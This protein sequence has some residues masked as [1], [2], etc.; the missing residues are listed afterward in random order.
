M[1]QNLVINPHEGVA[2]IETSDFAVMEI[3]TL[4]RA[5]SD[6]EMLQAVNY[7]KWKLAAGSFLEAEH[8]SDYKDLHRHCLEPL[9]QGPNMTVTASLACPANILAQVS[10]LSSPLNRHLRLLPEDLSGLS[11]P[12][13]CL[14][15]RHAV[16]VA[17][18]GLAHAECS[19]SDEKQLLAPGE[20]PSDM[21]NLHVEAEERTQD[22]H[23]ATCTVKGLVPGA[24]YLYVVFAR[25]TSGHFNYVNYVSVNHG[26]EATMMQDAFPHPR[27]NGVNVHVHFSS[28]A[29]APVKRPYSALQLDSAVKSMAQA[30]PAVEA[31]FTFIHLYQQCDTILLLGGMGVEHCGRPEYRAP[32]SHEWRHKRPLPGALGHGSVLMASCWTE[33]YRL[34]SR[35]ASL[36][37][38]TAVVA[39]ERLQCISGRWYNSL[40]KDSRSVSRSFGFGESACLS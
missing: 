11:T 40:S 37:G 31:G 24:Q 1:D 39:S 7:L 16:G 6:A 5:L 2:Y 13:Q 27:F 36:S 19:G 35:G 34:T 4:D 33:R 14:T 25:D 28:L 18:P 38:A 20:L 23:K 3:I 12:G 21:W 29:I 8:L 32:D 26:R 17:R 30:L 10:S 9:G 22:L 15:A